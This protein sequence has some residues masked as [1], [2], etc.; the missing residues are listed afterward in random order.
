MQIEAGKYYRSSDGRKFGPMRI[1][2]SDR[3]CW[4]DEASTGLWRPDGSAHF[5]DAKD[6]PR[7]VA[8]WTDAPTGPVVTE[9]VKRIVPGYYGVVEVTIDA[10][11][12]SE[13][14]IR[15]SSINGP[16]R[17]ELYLDADELRAAAATLLE[18]ADA[19]PHPVP[20]T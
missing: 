8:E 19:L 16:G 13:V 3:E 10:S 9:T 14:G 15:I 6:S 4:G 17:P 11:L 18:L 1:W 20:H 2:P 7:L 12:H 5:V